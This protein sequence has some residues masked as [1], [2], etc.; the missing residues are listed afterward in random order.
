MSRYRIGGYPSGYATTN[1]NLTR[2]S[3][4][5]TMSAREHSAFREVE[6]MYDRIQPSTK[7]DMLTFSLLLLLSRQRPRHA[8]MP[9]GAKP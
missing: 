4:N 1:E 9:C 8:R 2:T 5:L 7:S 6:C 3:K